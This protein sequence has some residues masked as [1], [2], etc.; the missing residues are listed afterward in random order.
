[1]AFEKRFQEYVRQKKLFHKKDKVLLAVSGGVDSVVMAE[2]FYRCKYNFGIAHCNFQLRGKDSDDDEQFVKRLA[3]KYK[4]PFYSVRFDTK[5]VARTSKLS[6][7]E[8]ARNLR[9]EWFH[10]ICRKEKYDCLS[11]AHHF[12]DSIETFFI[13]LLRGS[14]ITGLAGIKPVSEDHFSTRPLLFAT[15]KEIEDFAA[16]EKIK[17]RHDLSNEGDDYLRNRIRHHLIPMMI[18]LNPDFEKVMQRNLSNMLFAH[19]VFEAEILRKFFTLWKSK[20]GMKLD[21]KKMEAEDFSTELFTEW[22]RHFGF[23]SVQALDIWNSKKTGAQVFS[24][25]HVLTNDRTGVILTDRAKAEEKEDLITEKQKVISYSQGKL[26]LRFISGNEAGTSDLAGHAL[27]SDALRFPLVLRRWHAG[28]A[29]QPLGM[30]GKKKI[31]DF[32]TDK[33]VSRPDKEKTYVLL[34]GKNIVCVIGHRIDDR[35][36]VTGS[37]KKIYHIE[38]LT[39]E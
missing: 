4:K 33:K 31:S 2:I 29:F 8:A 39:N 3:G 37:T 21:R 35:Y 9:Y 28:D 20:P 26:K 1:M 11:T 13:N 15:R 7:Q 22:T 18:S 16:K 12:N 6:V 30:K 34:S 36:K 10:E 23:N 27:S 5:S 14:G 24:G 25:S 32:L 19:S 38:L 17:Y